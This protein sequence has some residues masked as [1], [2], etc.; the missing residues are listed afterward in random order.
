MTSTAT[1]ARAEAASKPYSCCVLST[2]FLT[3][4]PPP[5]LTQ[6]TPPGVLVFLV[7]V[8]ALTGHKL[9]CVHVCVC[10]CCVRGCVCVCCMQYTCSASSN[11]PPSLS[12][13]C[14]YLTEGST[15]C[16]LGLLMGVGLLVFHRYI[17]AGITRDLLVFNSATFFTYLLPPVIFHCGISVKKQ[18]ATMA[19]LHGQGCGVK[20]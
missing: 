12:S 1:G 17:R 15:A 9:R 7:C 8:W 19:R 3:T 4:P 6:F 11:L 20:P 16:L 14:R 5:T 18:V 2:S 10:M 13:R